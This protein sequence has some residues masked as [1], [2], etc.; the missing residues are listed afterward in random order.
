MRTSAKNATWRRAS[1]IGNPLKKTYHKVVHGSSDDG[2]GQPWISGTAYG[3]GRK[4]RSNRAHPPVERS[5]PITPPSGLTARQ[6]VLLNDLD[7]RISWPDYEI[8]RRSC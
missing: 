3:S 6:M 7:Y 4:N 2:P 5:L 8:A 1:V